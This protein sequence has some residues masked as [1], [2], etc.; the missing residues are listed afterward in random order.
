MEKTT[1]RSRGSVTMLLD[2]RYNNKQKEKEIKLFENIKT[3]IS[4]IISEQLKKRSKTEFEL[5]NIK[6]KFSYLKC[7]SEELERQ[8][9]EGSRELKMD[10]ELIKNY[11]EYTTTNLSYVFIKYE[12]IIN[13]LSD[14]NGYMNVKLKS[15]KENELSDFERAYEL[16][17]E[18]TVQLS[19]TKE[20]IISMKKG[21]ESLKKEYDRVQADIEIN[22]EEKNQV[23]NKYKELLSR[24]EEYKKEFEM[25]KEKCNS[26]M[27][28]KKQSS[29][30]L[31]KIEEQIEEMQKEISNLSNERNIRNDELQSLRDQHDIILND[32]Y[33]CN[34]HMNDKC[35]LLSEQIN[36]LENE[37]N[38]M[39]V[40]KNG[41]NESYNQLEIGLTNVS[42]SCEESKRENE[43][44]SLLIKELSDELI[45]KKTNLKQT[46]E[47]ISQISDQCSMIKNEY[48]KLQE[49]YDD[50]HRRMEALGI[51]MNQCR[52]TLQGHEIELEH[53]ANVKLENEKRKEEILHL[54]EN[55]EKLLLEQKNFFFKLS[56]LL[57]L[58]NLSNEQL[59][60]LKRETEDGPDNNDVKRTYDELKTRLTK[61]STDLY[62]KNEIQNSLQKEI[63][64]IAKRVTEGEEEITTLENEQA[65]LQNR[66]EMVT[67]EVDTLN[68]EVMKQDGTWEAKI[69]E[70]KCVLTQKYDQLVES[71]ASQI[72]NKQNEHN[73]FVKQGELE[74]LE[75]DFQLFH[76]ELTA[77]L[78]QECERKRRQIAEKDAQLKAYQERY[79][80][81][82]GI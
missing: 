73:S 29:I 46:Q 63:D 15:I 21:V 74:K 38:A 10:E 41:L 55:S 7:M 37:V 16:L 59:A 56:K 72:K 68:L 27:N 3:D 44:E 8:I 45:K 66:L 79:T 76:S 81:L 5:N 51:S 9:K 80:S 57:Q 75:F 1:K 60:N 39:E 24:I 36:Q 12:N 25:I 58:V 65:D 69:K 71:I 26:Q 67:R 34:S 61:L 42:N 48:T 22:G 4:L 2:S 33:R 35:E 17:L 82:K 31:N 77:T 20:N 47:E 50:V 30:D 13:D 28:E 23:E 70:T 53:L 6:K 54:M 40:E 49:N 19:A 62:E 11:F 32:L 78:E 18:R 43:K 64:D 52:A 14:Q